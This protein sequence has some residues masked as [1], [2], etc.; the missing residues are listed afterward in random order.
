M[1]QTRIYQPTELTEHGYV[2][3]TDNAANHVRRVLRLGP[4]DELTLFNGG[5]RDFSGCIDSVERDRVVVSVGEATTIERESPVRISLLQGICRGQRMDMLIQK[6]TE[7]G[8]H[9]IQPILTER[10]VVKIAAERIEKKMNHWQGIAVGACEQSGRAVVPEILAP[11][12]LEEAC[13]HADPETTKVF[14]DPDGQ[15]NLAALVESVGSIALL[16]GPE[17]GLTRPERTLVSDHGFKSVSLGPRI[18][19]TETAPLAAISVI[20][21]LAGDFR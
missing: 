9:R 20:Q 15:E 7:L 18:L 4:G 16:I 13:L 12:T 2:T 8:V 21:Y 14:L 6:S 5:G 17:G 10:V 3:L 11:G 19:R 1:R